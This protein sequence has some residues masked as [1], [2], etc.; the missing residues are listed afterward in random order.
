MDKLGE[1]M[2]RKK[3]KIPKVDPLVQILHAFMSEIRGSNS[4]PHFKKKSDNS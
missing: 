2:I 4:C 3:N 1:K